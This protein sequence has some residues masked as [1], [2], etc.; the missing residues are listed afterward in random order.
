MS[1]GIGDALREARETQGRTP[2]DAA[3]SIH[4]RVDYIH[5]LETERFEVFGADT[6]AKGFLKEYAR[7]LGLDPEPLL[8]IYREH[9][10][11]QELATSALI[12]APVAR[13]QRATPSPWIGWVLA[14]VLGLVGLAGLGNLLGSRTPEPATTQTPPPQPAVTD[15]PSEDG[16]VVAEPSPAPTPT[17]DGVNLLLAFE[18]DSWIRVEVD[19][20]Q[21]E[22]GVIT[23]GETREYEADEEVTIRYGNAGGVRVEFNGDGMGTPGGR[24][25]VI[26]VTYT[27]DGP[28]TEA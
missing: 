1:L 22:E 5:A 28:T 17:F 21:I 18:E 16:S 23:A 26:E 7:Y 13:P 8:V 15:T 24:G 12:A 4:T 9:V 27:P 2:E 6:Y 20:Q 14:G 3:R 19:G 25:E 10:G 11:E